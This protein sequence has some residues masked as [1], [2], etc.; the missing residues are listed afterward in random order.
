MCRHPVP[1]ESVLVQHLWCLKY[2]QLMSNGQDEGQQHEDISG[3]KMVPGHVY[4]M[5]K[6]PLLGK[7]IN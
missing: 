1:N 5:G 3:K 2:V 6:G 7:K 4:A